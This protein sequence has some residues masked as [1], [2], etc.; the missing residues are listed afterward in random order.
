M[1]VISQSGTSLVVDGD[2]S[3]RKLWIGEQYSFSYTLSKPY[4]KQAT[5]SGGKSNVA[6]GRFQVRNGVIT[7]DDTV[8]FKVNVSI[9]GRNTRTH[10]FDYRIPSD[11][12]TLG[13]PQS[14]KDGSFKFPIRSRGD[15][16]DI[17]LINDTPYPSC[18]LTV[19]YEAT[20]YNRARRV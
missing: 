17:E 15:R 19:E 6:S 13:S 7:F 20:Y 1:N 4:L 8:L 2:I 18:F 12:F 16:V 9:S 11:S 10:V 3:S 14:T 5:E